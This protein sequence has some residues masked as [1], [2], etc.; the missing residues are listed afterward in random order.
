MSIDVNDT[1]MYFTLTFILFMSWSC[2]GLSVFKFIRSS[3]PRTILRVFRLALLVWM[4]AVY[5]VLWIGHIPVYT[6][7]SALLARLGVMGLFA[8][9]FVDMARLD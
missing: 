1:F 2:L 9:V 8:L 3:E 5:T 6:E 7:M 4:A